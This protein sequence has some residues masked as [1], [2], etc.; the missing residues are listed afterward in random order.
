MI[1]LLIGKPGS[2]KTKEMIQNANASLDTTKGTVLFIN[3]SDD[4][5]L[6]INHH[7]RY[8]NLSDF[9]L[10]SSNGIIPFI[11]GLLSTDHDISRIYLDG[12]FNLYV[13]TELEACQWLEKIKTLS[14]KYKVHFE[15]SLNVKDQIPECF[16]PF[17]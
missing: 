15:L 17:M 11:Y 12:I 7:I 3:E 10:E 4:S 6:Q 2:G 8:I 1:K 14:E 13:M 5:I 9:P 16:K